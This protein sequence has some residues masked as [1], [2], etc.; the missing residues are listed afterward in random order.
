MWFSK[1]LDMHRS[2]EE[3]IPFILELMGQFLIK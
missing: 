2:G 1:I 3:F